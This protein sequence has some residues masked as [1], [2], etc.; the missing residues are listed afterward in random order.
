MIL[1]GSHV[2]Y[3]HV[4]TTQILRALYGILL[5]LQIVP[6]ITVDSEQTRKDASQ[7]RNQKLVFWDSPFDPTNVFLYPLNIVVP[8]QSKRGP[9]KALLHVCCRL[10][11]AVCCS[12]QKS[13][14][15]D[16]VQTNALI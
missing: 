16:R 14:K 11:P 2:S 4:I 7:A 5:C 3:S 10:N 9:M 13:K 1:S 15:Q 12:M 8:Q 6:L